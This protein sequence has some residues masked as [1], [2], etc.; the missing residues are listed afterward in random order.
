MARVVQRRTGPPYLLITFVFLFLISAALAVLGFMGADKAAEDARTKDIKIRQL[1]EENEKLTVQTDD[2]VQLTTG[3]A[4]TPENAIQ[5]AEAAYNNPAYKELGGEQGGLA[6]ELVNLAKL[7]GDLKKA[8]SSLNAQIAQSNDELANKDAAIAKQTETHKAT[9]AEL[10]QQ[11]ADLTEA[12]ERETE[13]RTTALEE[14]EVIFS[15]TREKLEK[16]IKAKENQLEALILQRQERDKTIATLRKERDKAREALHPTEG[17]IDDKPDGQIEKVARG[18]DVCYINLGSKDRVR[19]EMT[20]TVHGKGV[21]DGKTPKGKILVTNVSSNFSECRIIEQ[22]ED[23]PIVVGDNVVNLAFDTVRTY[24]FVV[25]GEFDLHNTQT[26]SKF[27]TEEI[28][29]A[30]R[31]FGGRINDEID[32]QTDY[33]VMGTEPNKPTKPLPDAIGPVHRAYQKQLKRYKDYMEV[34]TTA[35]T[36]KIPILNTNRFLL[37]TGYK[38]EKR[39]E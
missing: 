7:V 11:K 30:I 15:G 14:A 20:F 29:N 37:L 9:V 4:G 28:K 27:G 12:L 8:I 19:P 24:V 31:R 10:N 6:T 25:K 3:K 38:P 17:D 1:R 34:K 16:D 13:A 2:L 21:I 26:P 5:A 39:P 35:E 18:S 36:M 33:V 32:I 22:D 23:S